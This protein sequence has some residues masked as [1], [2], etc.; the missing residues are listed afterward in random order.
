MFDFIQINYI[1]IR[2][3]DSFFK[4]LLLIEFRNIFVHTVLDRKTPFICIILVKKPLTTG[5]DLSNSAT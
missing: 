5:H 1:R 3:S 4:I 2:I